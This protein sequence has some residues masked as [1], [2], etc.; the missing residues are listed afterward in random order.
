MTEAAFKEIVSNLM[1]N[2]DDQKLRELLAKH[3]LDKL[4]LTTQT[5]SVLVKKLARMI[6]GFD[7]TLSGFGEMQFPWIVWYLLMCILYNIKFFL[8]AANFFLNVFLSQVFILKMLENYLRYTFQNFLCW[9][10]CQKSTQ[11][12]VI[13]HT[14]W[15]K[16]LWGRTLVTSLVLL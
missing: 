13:H 11:I 14:F 9:R 8:C 5:K 6:S 3:N 7:G 16:E 15:L 2:Y 10:G 1:T 4:P 12:G